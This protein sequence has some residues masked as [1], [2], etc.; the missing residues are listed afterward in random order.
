MES[1]CSCCC[2]FGLSFAPRLSP[3]FALGPDYC[4]FA[5][6]SAGFKGESSQKCFFGIVFPYFSR[7]CPRR[8]RN[9]WR[10]QC[11]MVCFCPRR[12]I[13]VPAIAFFF[14]LFCSFIKFSHYQCLPFERRN[15]G[16][17]CCCNNCPF[18]YYF[19]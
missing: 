18:K 15:D 12:P 10:N 7:V 16:I 2:L 14:R 8:E 9:Q 13:W 3:Y 4:R 19:Y 5:W 1:C 11:W 17:D 6:L